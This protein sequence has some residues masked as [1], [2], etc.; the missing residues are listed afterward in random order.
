M[1]AEP[2]DFLPSQFGNLQNGH[3]V[4]EF[5]LDAVDLGLGHARLLVVLAANRA[6]L[7]QRVGDNAS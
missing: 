5:D 7:I 1:V 2:G 6:G 4:L 3:T